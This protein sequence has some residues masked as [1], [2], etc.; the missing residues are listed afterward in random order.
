MQITHISGTQPNDGRENV[1]QSENLT[2]SAPSVQPTENVKNNALESGK[3]GVSEGIITGERCCNAANNSVKDEAPVTEDAGSRVMAFLDQCE[4][5]AQA[6]AEDAA[7]ADAAKRTA[8]W[9]ACRPESLLNPP[10]D[11]PLFLHGESIVMIRGTLVALK[12]RA[13]VGK[14]QF[15]GYLTAAMLKDGVP[16]GGSG[17]CAAC[18]GLKILIIDTEMTEEQ[19]VAKVQRGFRAAGVPIPDAP[20]S[21]RVTILFVKSRPPKEIIAI[22]E[23]AIADLQPDL[24]VID[25]IVQ[26]FPSFNDEEEANNALNWLKG[27]TLGEGKPCVIA[28]LH[29][30]LSDKDNSAGAKMRGHLGTQLEL[31]A[32]TIISVSKKDR[33]FTA[34]IPDGRRPEDCKISWE[35]DNEHGMYIPARDPSDT[36]M[37]KD[38]LDH[39][40]EIHNCMTQLAQEGE[41]ATQAAIIRLYKDQTGYGKTAAYDHFKACKRARLIVLGIGNT[42]SAPQ[43]EDQVCSGK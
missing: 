32:D 21:D 9:Q 30:N 28:V 34:E 17:I 20:S 23:A 14:S 39:F 33:V 38:L 5:D 22:T 3:P 31:S 27:L 26:L 6:D 37:E 40:E 7:K 35:I 18:A 15:Y 43:R 19:G 4:D 2:L 12:G 25:G 11:N 13:K 16:V 36:G 24:V 10:K 8:M 42:Y 29:T 1:R 41:P